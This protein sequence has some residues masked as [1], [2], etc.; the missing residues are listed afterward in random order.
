[1]RYLRDAVHRYK[2]SLLALNY[3]PIQNGDSRAQ[4][5][6]IFDLA[7]VVWSEG[8]FTG[9]GDRRMDTKSGWTQQFEA[10]K[11]LAGRASKGLIING[12]AAPRASRPPVTDYSQIS[13]DDV[14]WVLANYLLVK[15][16]HTYTAVTTGEYGYFHDL[17]DY[18][19]A[20]GKARGTAFFRHGVWMRA[21]TNGLAIVNPDDTT[22]RD[23]ALTAGFVDTSGRP[24]RH[25]VVGPT[26]GVI[27]LRS[28]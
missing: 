8:G 9:W 21:F 28:A 20:I 7:D 25:A 5:E 1:V 17:A 16:G 12:I 4:Y 11:G 27:L 19:I 13:A 23:V 18:H 2:D 3:N 24:V 26:S 6:R 10:L 22:S 14:D 15:G